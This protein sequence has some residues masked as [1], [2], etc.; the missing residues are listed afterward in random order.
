MAS[1]SRTII[2][3]ALIGNTLVALSKFIASFVSGSS[4]MFSEAI[5]SVVDTGNQALLLYGIARAARPADERFPFGYGKEVYF[6]SFIVAILIFSVGAGLSIYEGVHALYKPKPLGDPMINYVVL[7]LAILFEGVA[8]GMAL[9][10]FNREKGRWGMIEAVKREKNPSTFVILFEDSAA[11][12]GLLIALLGVFLTQYTGNPVYDGVA[13]VIIGLILAFAAVWLAHE[14]K[15]LLIGEAANTEV[16]DSIRRL[17]QQNPN[18]M[19]VNEV[20]TLHMGPEYIL[21]NLSVDFKDELD[22]T[23][24]EQAVVFIDR[25]IKK[26]HPLIKRVFIEAEARMAKVAAR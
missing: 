20:L 5:H 1:G 12:A 21:F 15:G 3:A 2:I 11:L 7:S 26:K 24:I 6:W 13:S 23:A 8:W 18:V 22:A 19:H 9:R 4:A 10:Q 17:V 16:V 14:T 25:Q